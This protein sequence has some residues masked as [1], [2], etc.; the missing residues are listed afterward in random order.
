[1]QHYL[2]FFCDRLSS[3]NLYFWC[4]SCSLVMTASAFSLPGCFI[5]DSTSSWKPPQELWKQSS[6]GPMPK[7]HAQWFNSK[8]LGW[9]YVSSVL[10][11]LNKFIWVLLPSIQLPCNAV[12]KSILKC[13]QSVVDL[14]M[15]WRNL[16]SAGSKNSSGKATFALTADRLGW[17]RAW[18]LLC[19]MTNGSPLNHSNRS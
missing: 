17:K 1:M 9:L 8:H 7:F 11:N 13:G 15:R 18:L 12:D 19:E 5:K 6:H 16:A 2:S 10:I 3:M 14:C 4:C